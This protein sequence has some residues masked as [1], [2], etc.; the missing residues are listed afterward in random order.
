[1]A[2]ILHMVQARALTYIYGMLK[3]PT[4][5][6]FSSEH[7]QGVRSLAW[8]P[9]SFDLASSGFDNTI[10]IWSMIAS[11]TFA[12]SSTLRA[13]HNSTPLGP[14]AW[15]SHLSFLASGFNDATVKIFD[16]ET[17][18]SELFSLRTDAFISQLQ[19]S[20]DGLYLAANSTAS[21]VI[22]IWNTEFLN[23]LKNITFESLLF[24][25]AYSANDIGE[26]SAEDD[27]NQTL[28]RGFSLLPSALRNQIHNIKL[29][30]QP[31]QIPR[32]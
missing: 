20:S 2:N 9:H 21:D 3:L 6:T 18:P 14:L 28:Q 4:L 13:S 8:A 19:W 31:P 16:L 10:K 27:H 29:W 12:H 30:K 15:H 26:I 32:R 7:A 24:L 5:H 23:A 17:T 22:M 25:G 1:M 11:S